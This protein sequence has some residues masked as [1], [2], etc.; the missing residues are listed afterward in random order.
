M[1][2][3]EL[4]GAG[5]GSGG[6]MLFTVI[7]M[8]SEP[9][10]PSSSVTVSLNTRFSVAVTIGAV[11]DAF[12]MSAFVIVTT[13]PLTWAQLNDAIEPSLSV[14]EPNKLTCAPSSTS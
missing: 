11:N 3:P 7:V 2:P 1:P 5:G 6:G 13:V 4:L 8:V 12:A 10:A 9:V 14:P